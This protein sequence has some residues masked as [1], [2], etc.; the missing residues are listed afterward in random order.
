MRAIV[1]AC[2]DAG[3]D[4][5]D[6]DGFVSYGDDKN[7]PVRLMSELRTKELNWSMT[8][9]GG[10]GIAGAF[11]DAAAAIISGQAKA[12]VVFRALVQDVSGRL[13]AAVMA[14]HLNRH[15]VAAGIVAPAQVCAM[16]AQR[17]FDYHG[18]PKYRRGISQ[19]LLLSW[20]P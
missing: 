9:F 20:Q 7:E 15:M 4:P 6:I 3:L 18:V 2:A 1:D 11:A 5:A 13:S 10:G 17:L 14:H 12:V 19:G 8:V 16:R